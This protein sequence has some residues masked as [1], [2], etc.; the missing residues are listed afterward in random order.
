MLNALI[1]SQ[2]RLVM[3]LN[4]LHEKDNTANVDGEIFFTFK[5]IFLRSQHGLCGIPVGKTVFLKLS[6]G[7]HLK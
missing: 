2:L 4:C 7:I 1:T 6:Q 3:A 5:D